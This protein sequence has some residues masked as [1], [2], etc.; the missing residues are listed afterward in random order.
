M[1]ILQARIVKW[2]P[3]PFS[4]GSSQPRDQTQ[5]SRI[6]GGFFTIWTTREAQRD[7]YGISDVGKAWSRELGNLKAVLGA[8][9]H[10]TNWT[11]FFTGYQDFRAGRRHKA[12]PPTGPS[13]S[14]DWLLRVWSS[15]QSENAGPLFRVMKNLESGRA[16]LSLGP[17][18]PAHITCPRSQLCL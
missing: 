8:G 9:R 1:G 18:V 11:E 2:V 17:R 6:A 14:Q 3:Y 15:V 4:R 7:P 12:P 13:H 5:V 10:R 16:V